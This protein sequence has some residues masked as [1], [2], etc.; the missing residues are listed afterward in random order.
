[1]TLPLPRPARVVGGF[2]VLAALLA[3]CNPQT[4][5]TPEDGQ[6]LTAEFET[7]RNLVAG[8]AVRVADV[9]VGTVTGVE[10]V[11]YR[12]VVTMTIERERRIPAGTRALIQKT[13]LLGE[14]YV[15][16]QFPEEFDP[17]AGP[18]LSDGDVITET[19]VLPDIEQVA[20][21]A[22]EFVGALAADDL[23]TIFDAASEGLVGNGQLINQLIIDLAAVAGAY[24]DNASS[25]GSAIDDFGALGEELAAGTDDLLGMLDSV[26]G[27]TES[28]A[29]QRTKL[30]GLLDELSRLASIIDTT[31][32][33][34]SS[35]ALEDAL[36]DLAPIVRT[37]VAERATL[38]ELLDGLEDFVVKIQLAVNDE[39]TAVFGFLNPA[40][41]PPSS[42][43]SMAQDEQL[44]F[45]MRPGP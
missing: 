24:G 32:I 30:V 23:S 31:L 21:K 2:V 10:L 40:G 39:L 9:Q 33:G 37:L 43:A 5:G 44:A 4:A 12:A 35:T 3:G 16:L 19:E 36:N 25:F 27:I 6:V 15:G 11:D 14:N 7:V 41:P 29:R 17:V 42:T 45:L 13:S 18:F 38:E 34:E 20:G 26:E 8:H 1:M 28:T 22:A